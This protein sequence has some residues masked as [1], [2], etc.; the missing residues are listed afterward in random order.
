[1]HYYLV[2]TAAMRPYVVAELVD[3]PV[4]YDGSRRPWNRIR[5]DGSGSSCRMMPASTSHSKS[6]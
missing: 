1:M 2:R 6:C 3:Q 4:T 5:P